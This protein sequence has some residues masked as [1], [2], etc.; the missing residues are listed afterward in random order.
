MPKWMK[1]GEAQKY[2]ESLFDSQELRD[3]DKPK[4]VYDKYACFRDFSLD[5]F[6]KNF[7][8]TKKEFVN[9]NKSTITPETTTQKKNQS[10]RNGQF[11]YNDIF[12]TSF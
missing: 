1:D 10:K 3:S 11:S 6:R 8:I 4:D 9:S 7:A 5:V 12:Y 2:L